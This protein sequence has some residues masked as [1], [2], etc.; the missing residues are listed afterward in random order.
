M[1]EDIQKNARI[2]GE[3]LRSEDGIQA[4]V[5]ALYKFIPFRNGGWYAEIYE[6]QRKYPVV[7]WTNQLM[8]NDGYHFSNYTGIY[9]YKITIVILLE[10]AL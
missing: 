10:R 9:Y 5:E 1:R 2:L 8:A 3:K 7:Q 6:F 4:G